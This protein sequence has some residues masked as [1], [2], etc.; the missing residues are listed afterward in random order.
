MHLATRM[1]GR[2]LGP[3][4]AWLL[5]A[6]GVDL[7]VTRVL[8]RLA[9]FIPKDDAV[10]AI[11]GLVARGGAVV[12]TLVAILTLVLLVAILSVPMVSVAGR[13]GL[14][15]TAAVAIGGLVLLVTPITPVIAMIVASLVI[16]AASALVV[17]AIRGGPAPESP[18]VALLGAAIALPA[19]ARLAAAAGALTEAP[20]TGSLGAISNTLGAWTFLAGAGLVG[21]GGLG[22][23]SGR[24]GRRPRAVLAG[25]LVG[26]IA[27]LFALV[28]PVTAQQLL[29]WSLGLPSLV[30][31]VVMAAIAGLA[32][33]GL[34]ALPPERR[35]AG[36][37]L[38]IV[39]LAGYGL[40]ASS[41][42]LAGLLGLTVT[43]QALRA[44]R[45]SNPGTGNG[46]V[47]ATRRRAFALRP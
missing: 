13:L 46:P 43:G 20:W 6:L 11:V 10:A 18:G 22:G 32:A 30:H 9:I 41:L 42:L 19:A 5:V 16:I 31:P 39:L 37:G 14:A 15:A 29:I 38:G 1:S 26:G 34:L 47:E 3:I 12:E 35:L 44:G 8:L 7:L 25:G 40:A 24:T 23:Q 21:V 4:A 33:A 17:A 28:Q 45:R 27:G 2:A 36:T